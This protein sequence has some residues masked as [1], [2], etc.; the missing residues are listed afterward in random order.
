M[1]ASIHPILEPPKAKT[2]AHSDVAMSAS[3]HC[4]VAHLNPGPRDALQG[5]R[6]AT[7]WR[8]RRRTDRGVRGDEGSGLEAAGPMDLVRTSDG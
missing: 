1:D 5:F 4:V 7:T 6:A 2:L 3:S 8:A